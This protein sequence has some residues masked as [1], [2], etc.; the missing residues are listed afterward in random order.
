VVSIVIAIKGGSM[1]VQRYSRLEMQAIISNILKEDVTI[2]PIGNHELRR[3]LV[4]RVETK[5]GP[6]VFKYYYQDIYGGREISALKLLDKSSIPHA[7]LI[8]YGV[9]GSDREWLMMTLLEGMP[10]DKIMKHMSKEN[11]RDVYFDMGKVLGQIHESQTFQAFGDLSADNSFVKAYNHF[12]DAFNANNQY[13]Y[14]KVYNSPSKVQAI[15][16]TAIKR[17]E[18]NMALLDAVKTPQLTHMDYS[19]RN[20]FLSKEKE[21]RVFKAVFDFELCRP[22]DKNAD[23]S[24][25]ILRDFSGHPDFEKSFY[26]GYETVSSIDDL[27]YETSDFYTLNL[28]IQVCSWAEEVAPQYFDLALKTLLKILKESKTLK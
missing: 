2:L 22:W 8:D 28:C 19:P 6:F 27:F 3:H 13:C 10:M 24:Q 7:P 23:F 25:L 18:K 14:D 5:K 20:I 11:L 16:I 12:G 1:A 17:I 15:L 21:K 4:Y 26:E 9:F